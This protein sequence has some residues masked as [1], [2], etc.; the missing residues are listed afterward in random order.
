M[1]IKEIFGKKDVPGDVGIEIEVEAKQYLPG[2]DEQGIWTAI[3]DHSL[4]GISKEYISAKPFKKEE[5]KAN[6]IHLNDMLKS[7]GPQF[8]RRTSVHAHVNVQNLTPIQVWN[9][10][11][12]MWIVE[13]LL[14]HFAGQERKGNLFCLGLDDAEYILDSCMYNIKTNRFVD[15]FSQDMGK[16]SATNLCNIRSLNTIEN[17]ML[18]GTINPEV[19]S[20]WTDNLVTMRD[21]LSTKYR[22]PCDI[23]DA[24]F[25]T[26]KPLDF[27]EEFVSPEMFK[28]FLTVPDHEE[29][30]KDSFYTVCQFIYCTMD[31]DEWQ[32]KYLINNKK[33]NEAVLFRDDGMFIEVQQNP[34]QLFVEEGQV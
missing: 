26:K 8:S 7:C 22:N 12:G 32:S 29:V 24:F 23:G 14:F 34:P 9:V 16:Y 30:F 31:W 1:F 21:Q 28:F 15:G 6:V 25:A 20:M 13:P 4:R 3:N 19:I 27:L 18:K 11:T 17:R 33:I 2:Y 10:V 5:V